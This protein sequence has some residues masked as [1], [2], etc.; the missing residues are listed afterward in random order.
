MNEYTYWFVDKFLALVV[1][2]A[3]HI[4]RD[5]QLYERECFSPFFAHP[6]SH[7]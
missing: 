6:S 3:L 5:E 7:T 2:G 1:E 4:Q